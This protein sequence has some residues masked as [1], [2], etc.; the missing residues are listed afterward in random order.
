MSEDNVIARAWRGATSI[1][2]G[3]RYLRYLGETGVAACRGT[4]GNRGVYVLR[5][6]R[7]GRAEFLFL[8]LWDSADSIRAFAGPHPEHA[9]FFPQDDEFLV[10]REETVDH[11]EVCVAP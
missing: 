11:Y 1:E 2:D 10:E 9:V 3:D 5:R 7:E 6:E 4:G 8:S